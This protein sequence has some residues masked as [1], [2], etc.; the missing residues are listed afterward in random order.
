VTREREHARC[1]CGLGH[2]G[3]ARPFAFASSPRHYERDRPFAIEHLALDLDLDVPG[4][5]VS[6]EARLSVRRVDATAERIELDAVGFRLRSVR[7]D[8][9]DVKYTYDGRVLSAAIPKGAARAEVQVRYAATPRRGLYFIEPDEH[10]PAKPRQVWSQCQEEDARHFVPC[11][12]KPHQKMT[13]ELSVV[14]PA[15]WYALSNGRLASRAPAGEGR[16][17]FHWTM[18]EPHAS[19]LLTLVAGE[20]A[21]IT[22]EVDG[23]PLQYLFPPGREVDARR[24][25]ERTPEMIRVLGRLFGVKYPWN[26]Y[27]QVVVSDF[28]FGGMENTTATT[29]Y[30]H[31]LL[32]ERAAID[33]TSDDLVVHELA[34]QWFGD[35]VTCR[36]W[37]EGWLNE[38][39]AT[40]LEHAWREHRLG[41]DEYDYGLAVDRHAYLAEAGGRYRRPIVCQ[42]YDAPL[43]L[44]DRHLYEKGS[45]VLHALR[46]ELGADVFW[47]G[48]NVYLTRHARGVVETRDLCRALEEVSGRSL[49]RFFDLLVMRPGHVEASVDV[50]WDAGVLSVGVKQTQSATDGV[51]S[52]FELPLWI[53]VW[54]GGVERRERLDLR[55]RTDAFVLPCAERPDYVVIDPDG[56]LLGDVSVKA[57]LDM[58]RAQLAAPG[59]ARARWLAARALS[60]TD[61]PPSIDALVE[62][63]ADPR[64][65]WMVRAE[66]AEALGHVRAPECQA[67][68]LA[69]VEDA[70]PKVRRA[71]VA[72]LG[73]FRVP[74]VVAPLSKAVLGDPSYL[75]VADAARALGRTRQTAAMDA[76]L[77]VVDR[78]SWADV[79]S[80]GALDGLA[81]L[82]DDRAAP[83]VAVRTR[84][85]HP[86]RARRAAIVALARLSPE[87]KTRELLEDLLD[88]AD[89]YLRIDV[90]RALVEIGDGRSRGALRDRLERDLDPRVRRRIREA[91]RDLADAKR[92][93]ERTAERL[94]KLE[95]DLS[96]IRARLARLDAGKA[97][98]AGR[99]SEKT[100]AKPKAKSGKRKR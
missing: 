3:A 59:L 9:K 62:R 92:G 83:H 76:L 2:G 75:V 86:T 69:H 28:I 44:F 38:G 31:V 96:E 64:E 27:A 52:V 89:P 12:D 88:D 81:E 65:A 68:L 14:V 40:Y 94:E 8:G 35:Y 4:K 39:F 90:V 17:R 42:D 32:D 45:L 50:G 77:D 6:G 46:C 1:G 70:H 33:V 56:A 20:L 7:V 19:Y 66:A 5:S 53:A 13:T 16:E 91:L 82:R 10:H 51:P 54:T 41:R 93:G 11:H 100:A 49:G 57:P 84:Y 60:K 98:A 67:A 99:K 85:G 43:D 36:D 30:E 25:F 26:K 37:S 74:A 24:T 97:P 15:G 72:A 23:I 95:A 47:R 58:L 73:S 87:K 79:V 21:E 61:D 63:L 22:D 78:P 34:H 71:V 48:V 29:L 80:A 55:S 18:E